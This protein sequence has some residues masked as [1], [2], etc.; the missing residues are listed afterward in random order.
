MPEIRQ[1]ILIELSLKWPLQSL[2]SSLEHPK[3]SE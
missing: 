2:K 1:Q 3:I